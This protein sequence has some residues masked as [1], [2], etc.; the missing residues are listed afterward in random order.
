MATEL[1]YQP[2]LGDSV[3]DLEYELHQLKSEHGRAIAQLSSKV[4][5]VEAALNNIITSN[6]L[7]FSTA[8]LPSNLNTKLVL[9]NN[10]APNAAK[11][12][13]LVRNLLKATFDFDDE[14]LAALKSAELLGDNDILFDAGSILNKS[15][16]LARA[17]I[18][19]SNT[20]SVDIQ[21]Y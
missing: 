16:I 14:I 10:T 2:S 17:Q 6:S 3:R 12:L 1:S 7:S 5:S 19:E 15:M 11:A 8:R 21:N 18:L 20:D 9:K 4:R 13:V